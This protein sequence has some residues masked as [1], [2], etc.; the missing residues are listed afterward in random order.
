GQDANNVSPA[1]APSAITVGAVDANDAIASFS[2]FGTSVDIFATG[3]KVQSVGIKSD[4]A[5]TVLSG[6]SM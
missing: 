2:N 1:S 5:S 4:T 6:T 3:V